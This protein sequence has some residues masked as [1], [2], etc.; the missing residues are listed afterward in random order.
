MECS[1]CRL[2]HCTKSRKFAG[3]LHDVVIGGIHWRY[4]SGR[5][6]ALGSA[7]PP[8]EMSTR[9]ISLGLTILLPSCADG[10]EI[11]ETSNS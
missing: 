9:S 8:A 3:S 2:N 5:T 10:L 7:Q 6:M 1:N 4:P 11:L